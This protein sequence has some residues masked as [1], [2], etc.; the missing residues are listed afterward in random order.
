MRLLLLALSLFILG[1]QT[2]PGKIKETKQEDYAKLEPQTSAVQVSTTPAIPV[3]PAFQKLLH[4]LYQLAEDQR[5]PEPQLLVSSD[6]LYVASCK[7]RSNQIILEKNA[8][9]VC[10]EFGKDSTAL[11]GFLLGHEL[12]H[13]LAQKQD[14][15]ADSHAFF[16][17]Y[18]NPGSGEADEGNADLYGLFLCRLAGFTQLEKQLPLFIERLYGRYRFPAKLPGYPSKVQRQAYTQWIGAKTDSLWQIWEAGLFLLSLKQF[19][20]SSACFEYLS[21][22]YQGAEVWHNWG[23]AAALHAVQLQNRIKK[24]PYYPFLAEGTLRLESFRGPLSSEE[25]Q[26]LTQQLQHALLALQMAQEQRPTHLHTQLNLMMVHLLRQDSEVALQLFQQTSKRLSS[27]QSLFYQT[28][29]GLHQ[30]GI[31]SATIASLTQLSKAKDALIA[32]AALQ[33]LQ[34]IQEGPSASGWVTCPPLNF[35]PDQLNP[36]QL[37]RWNDPY[38]KLNPQYAIRWKSL[39][40]S[41]LL[42]LLRHA[43]FQRSYLQIVH[44]PCPT[45]YTDLGGVGKRY[46]LPFNALSTS[47]T[48]KHYAY[49]PD[50][51]PALKIEANHLVHA[52]AHLLPSGW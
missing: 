38:L 17:Y 40:H 25:E 22:F 1:C 5:L 24:T 27:E 37:R 2:K 12:G 46:L 32:N 30:P 19:A 42:T 35:Y 4:Q 51:G 9:S 18:R 36:A 8:L 28:L 13:L 48:K 34:Q 14:Q 6:S 50:C 3:A 23:T 20:E 33:N 31:D 47:E 49:T 52:W 44:D 10:R 26:L 43:P 45:P 11:L 7:T 29:I 16:N 41:T 15:Q 21:R 39:Q